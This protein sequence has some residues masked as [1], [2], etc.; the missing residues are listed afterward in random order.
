MIFRLKSLEPSAHVVQLIG[1]CEDHK[2]GKVFV[3]EY[4]RHG[5]ALGLNQLLI[6]NGSIS[7]S[8]VTFLLLI[9]IINYHSLVVPM[10]QEPYSQ[11]S[12]TYLTKVLEIFPYEIHSILLHKITIFTL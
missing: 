5:N 6:K 1:Y 7:R 12:L 8:K 10:V 2:K 3:S 9:N 11:S 4:H